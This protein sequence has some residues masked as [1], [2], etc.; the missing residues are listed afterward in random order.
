MK[1]SVEAIRR[2]GCSDR[3]KAQLKKNAIV[4][5][6]I[7]VEAGDGESLLMY[8]NNGSQWYQEGIVVVSPS[9]V[10]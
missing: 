5:E 4:C 7:R 2:S 9:L 3:M 1:E 6:K 10:M 8:C